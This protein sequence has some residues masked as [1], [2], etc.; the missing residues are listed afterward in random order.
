V[1]QILFSNAS[2]L[3]FVNNTLTDHIPLHRSIKKKCHLTPYL[4]VLTVDALGYLL[5]STSI[6][7]RICDV[8]LPDDSKMINNHLAND[9]FLSIHLEKDS[10]QTTKGCLDTFCNTLKHFSQ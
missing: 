10:I 7:G 3:V 9:S 1:I 8:T 2:T 4:Y 6:K 5:E